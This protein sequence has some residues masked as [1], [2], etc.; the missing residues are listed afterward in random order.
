[1]GPATCDRCPFPEG[2][3]GPCANDPARITWQR[4]YDHGRA[5]GRDEGYREA[6]RELMVVGIKSVLRALREEV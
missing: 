3:E 2:H 4:G 6:V 5:R 1:M